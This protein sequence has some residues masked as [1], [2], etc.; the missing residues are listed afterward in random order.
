QLVLALRI[1]FFE[2]RF[3]AIHACNPPD[4]IFLVAGIFKLLFRTRFVFDHH[5]LCP[6]L[7]EA[8]FGR[9]TLLYRVLILLERMTFRLADRTIAT[10]D[11]YRKIAIQRGRMHP[12]EVTVVRSGPDTQRLRVSPPDPSLRC[13]RRFLVSYIGVMG[14]Q[15]GI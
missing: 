3:H 6:E 9:R 4:T 12:D 15:E 7:Y 5:D 8:K 11:S 13:G 1:F 10:N 14:H 2:R